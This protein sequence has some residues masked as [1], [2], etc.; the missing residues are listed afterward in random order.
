M[1]IMKIGILENYLGME[2][3]IKIK[4]LT[5]KYEELRGSNTEVGMHFK[6]TR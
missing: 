3:F 1:E 5:L 4:F 6:K 2:F